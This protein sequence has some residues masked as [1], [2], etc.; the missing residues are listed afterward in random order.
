VDDVAAC[1]IAL[2]VDLVDVRALLQL[3]AGAQRL[4]VVLVPLFWQ[5]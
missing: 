4:V 2:D 5:S 3:D 1:N